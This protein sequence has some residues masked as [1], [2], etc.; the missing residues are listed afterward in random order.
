MKAAKSPLLK[1]EKVGA[2]FRAVITKR[3]WDKVSDW[4]AELLRAYGH[5]DNPRHVF[6]WITAKDELEA[7]MRFDKLWAGLPKEER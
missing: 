7:K 6:L 1:V 4:T 2:A 5:W 3:Q